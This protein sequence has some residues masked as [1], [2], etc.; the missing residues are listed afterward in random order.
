MRDMYDQ[1]QEVIKN[2]LF[3]V[4]VRKFKKNEDIKLKYKSQRHTNI[5]SNF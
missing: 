5:K 3:L 4:R 2:Y 1:I